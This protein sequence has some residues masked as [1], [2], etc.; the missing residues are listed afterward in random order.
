VPLKKLA[1]IT[2]HP[3]QYNAPWFKLLS[4][5]GIVSLKVFYT[6]GQLEDE[7]KFDPDFGKEVEWDIPLL[8][9]YRYQ[10]VENVSGHPGSDHFRGI[11]NPKLI[12]QIK[13]WNPDALLVFGWCFKSHLKVL[14]YF[15]GKKTVLFRGDSN[16]I[17]EPSGLSVKKFVR[18]IF[19]SWIYRHVDIALYVGKVNKAYYKRYGLAERQLFF[20]PHAVDNERFRQPVLT[21]DR[22]AL[23]VPDAATVF[24]FV[25]KFEEKKDPFVLLEAFI[26]LNEGEAHLLFVGNGAME[27]ELK[28]SVEKQEASLRKRIHFLPFQNQLQMPSVYRLGDVLVLPSR[29]P[30]ETWG[31]AVNEA[32]ACG[33]A[34]LVSDKCGC[35]AEL[36]QEGKNG[37][38]F[39]SGNCGDLTAK[40]KMLLANREKLTEMG[41][42]SLK[43]IAR[44]NFTEICMG[45]ESIMK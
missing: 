15:K 26:N 21:I 14:R 29:G 6:W 43:I 5:R 20:V 27:A 19:L 9:G 13:A 11:D 30:G 12:Q 33:K 16:L 8:E 31:L 32:M 44:W 17:D 37:Y 42:E 36:L 24:I 38:I 18:R 25:G 40:M 10:F 23:G 3:I 7:K 4:E 2:T 41:A 45:I 22:I 39:K 28:M 35:A 34:I 1:I